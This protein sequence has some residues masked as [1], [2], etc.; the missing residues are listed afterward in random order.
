VPDAGENAEHRP[1][2]QHREVLAEDDG[3][4]ADAVAERSGRA[5]DGEVW[6][7]PVP[8]ATASRLARRGLEASG[9]EPG[10]RGFGRPDLS[11]RGSL[12]AIRSQISGDADGE[13]ERG[14]DDGRIRSQRILVAVDSSSAADAAITAALEL[15]TALSCSIRFVHAASPLADQ[16]YS[17]DPTEGPSTEKIVAKDGVL[18]GALRRAR[19][20]GVD[21]VVELVGEEGD[22][23]DLAATIAGIASG[24]GA[25]LIVCGSRGRGSVAGTVLGSVSHNLIKYATVPVLIVHGSSDATKV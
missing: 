23:G 4:L 10:G 21:A 20:A 17:E 3:I 16:L 13:S 14:R 19:K 9:P 25:G 2:V 24:V 15:A 18:A 7:R 1:R 12:V 5:P 6:P 22:A 11:V 8:G